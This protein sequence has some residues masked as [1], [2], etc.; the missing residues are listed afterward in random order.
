MNYSATFS[1]GAYTCSMTFVASDRCLQCG[2]DPY[3]PP[4]KSLTK[5]EI[6]QYRA[7]RDALLARVARDLGN[8]LVIDI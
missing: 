7:G 8:V 1:V 3:Q 4:P 6:E 5:Q 2:W